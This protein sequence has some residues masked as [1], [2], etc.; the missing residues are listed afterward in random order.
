MVNLE[1]IKKQV[2]ETLPELKKLLEEI[3]SKASPAEVLKRAYFS[4]TTAFFLEEPFYFRI[5]GLSEKHSQIF[6]TTIAEQIKAACSGEIQVGNNIYHLRRGYEERIEQMKQSQKTVLLEERLSAPENINSSRKEELR[7]FYKNIK[8]SYFAY[9]CA[10][11]RDGYSHNSFDPKCNDKY[12]IH[13]PTELEIELEIGEH[14]K[15][16]HVA[17]FEDKYDLYH[18]AYFLDLIPFKE[19]FEISGSEFES[20]GQEIYLILEKSENL[21]KQ[22]K[23]KWGYIA[24]YS[25][26]SSTG[27]KDDGR[28]ASGAFVVFGDYQQLS[29]AV[30]TFEENP[31]NI[32]LFEKEVLFTEESW[33]PFHGQFTGISNDEF[34]RYPAKKIHFYTLE[35]GI[36][37][38]HILASPKEMK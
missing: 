24:L 29:K 7:Q 4:A 18:P 13:N 9:F 2:E 19:T 14:L 28:P 15:E 11:F 36:R 35:K 37:S 3:G 22:K 20:N 10:D 25:R 27:T 5:N 33:K 32:L 23:Q 8:T 21:S 6:L 34:G 12:L 26:R 17:P 16:F 31:L 38:Y 30:D 1:L